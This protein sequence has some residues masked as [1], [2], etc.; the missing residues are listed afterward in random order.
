MRY[1]GSIAAEGDAQLI[2]RSYGDVKELRFVAQGLRA[3]ACVSNAGVK[4]SRKDEETQRAAFDF[5]FPGLHSELPHVAVPGVVIEKL[6]AA[7]EAGDVTGAVNVE[8]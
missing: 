7:V 2:F 4:R 3:V 8:E 6:V 1:A 5:V